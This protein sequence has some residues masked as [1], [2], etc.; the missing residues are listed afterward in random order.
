MDSYVLC[1]K[2][3]INELVKDDENFLYLIRMSGRDFTTLG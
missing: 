3:D 2:S 1:E